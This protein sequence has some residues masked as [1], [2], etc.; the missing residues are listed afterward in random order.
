MTYTWQ[1]N[2]VITAEKL[3]NLE[4]AASKP[5]ILVNITKVQSNVPQMI[6]IVHYDH[7]S[8]VNKIINGEPVFG[9]AYREYNYSDWVDGCTQYNTIMPIASVGIYIPSW[10]IDTFDLNA[11]VSDPKY[12]IVGINFQNVKFG[13]SSSTK[14]I[15]NITG[16]QLNIELYKVY[17]SIEQSMTDNTDYSVL[18]GLIN[19]NRTFS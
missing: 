12:F 4:I 1:T 5:D 16:D 7:N 9:Y 10:I 3:N 6:E 18:G 19:A 11:T 15:L 8:F 2:E 13:Y 17:D 14:T